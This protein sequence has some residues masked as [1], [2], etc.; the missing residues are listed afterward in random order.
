MDKED[1]VFWIG[2]VALWTVVGCILTGSIA[3]QRL[4][5]E[6]CRLGHAERYIKDSCT[7]GFRWLPVQNGGK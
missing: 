2:M 5:T 4:K 3:S 6:A 7:V 1:V